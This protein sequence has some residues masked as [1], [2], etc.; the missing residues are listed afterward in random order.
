M[1]VLHAGTR[2]TV[3]EGE[4]LKLIYR[5]QCEESCRVR[6][7]QIAKSIGVQPST[8]TETLQKLAEKGLLIY[9]RYHGVELT[10][11][12]I[13][14]AQK[15]LRKHRLLEV[16]FVKLLN[17]NVKKACDEASKLDYYTSMDLANA[18]CQIYKHPENCPCDKEIFRA[19]EC[20]EKTVE[21]RHLEMGLK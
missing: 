19:K 1:F 21:G 8:V 20:I 17:Y 10:K 7:T 16:L 15:L 6:T 2:I 12:G 11:R 5:K 18:I 9:R 14:E 4:Y 13:A 3:N